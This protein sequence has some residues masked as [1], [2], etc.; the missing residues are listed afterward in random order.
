VALTQSALSAIATGAKGRFK[1]P[2][3]AG[4][5]RS[6]D[7]EAL[8]YEQ[9]R[10][11]TLNPAGDNQPLNR[12]CGRASDRGDAKHGE[13][14]GK[15]APPTETIAGGAAHEYQA[16]EEEDVPIDDPLQGGERSVEVG[17]Q[18]RQPD[19]DDAPSPPARKDGSKF[20][21]RR[22]RCR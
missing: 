20:P 1:T 11:D 3:I 22:V 10:S 15:N 4:E 14:N 6:D 13:A 9:C 5:R 16:A 2:D 17:L 12:R 8:G 7:C 21:F 19:G 18:C